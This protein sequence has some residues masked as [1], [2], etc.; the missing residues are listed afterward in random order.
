M[1]A[2]R[3]ARTAL[4]LGLPLLLL[5][6]LFWLTASSSGLRTLAGWLASDQLQFEAVD[7]SLLGPLQVGR[8]RWQSAD[9]SEG[10]LDELQLDWSPV[11]LLAGE[12]HITSVSAK[13]LRLQPAADAPPSTAP[14]ALPL[15]LALRIDQL[16]LGGLDYAGQHWLDE[17]TAS[18]RSDGHHH[19]LEQLQLVRGET[20]LQATAEI[21]ADLQLSAQ[22]EL[23]SQLAG[24]AQKLSLALR[25]QLD[26]IDLSAKGEDGLLGEVS[27]RL[28]PF[29]GQPLRRLHLQL[30]KL[31]PAAWQAGWPQ[32][33]LRLEARLQADKSGLTG[34]LQ[35]ANRQAK[36][37]DQ[38]GL[39]ILSLRSQLDWQGERLRFTAL[40]AELPGGGN[41]GGHAEWQGESARL[42]LQASALDL[43]RL[44][45]RLRSTHLAGPISLQWGETQQQ[46]SLDLS[47]RGL[48]ARVRGELK[49]QQLNLPELELLAGDARLSARGQLELAGKGGFSLQG[50]LQNFDPAR[51]ARLPGGRLNADLALAGQ[52][53]PLSLRAR[54][55]LQDSRLGQVPLRGEAEIAYVRQRLLPS[56]L[57]LS[58]GDN[59]LEASGSFGAPEDRLRI[60][61][62]ASQLKAFGLGGELHGQIDMAGNWQQ[63]TLTG[64]LRSPR[65]NLPGGLTLSGLQLAGSLGSHETAAQSL[66]LRL[67]RLDTA[68]VP[69]LLDDLRLQLDGRRGAHRLN[70]SSRLLDDGRLQTTLAGGMN[71]DGQWQGQIEALSLQS[72]D[73]ARNFR[74]AAP[75][76]LQISPQAWQVGDLLLKGEKLDW[77]ARL[78]AQANGREL[79][80]SGQA[81]GSRL[82]E[83]SLELQAGLQDAYTLAPGAPWQGGLRARIADLAWLGESLGEGWQSGGQIDARISLAG[84]PAAPRFSGQVSGQQLALRLPEQG[85]HLSDGVLD[86]RLQAQKLRIER[87]HFASRLQAPPRALTQALQRDAEDR[88]AL[89]ALVAQPG[90]LEIGGEIAV[91]RSSADQAALDIRLERLGAW[92]LPDQWLLLS[93]NGRLAWRDGLLDLNGQIAADAGY[94]QLAPGGAPQLS[95]DVFV[96]RAGDAERS[97]LR[98]RR[99]IDLAVD[100]GRRFHFNG[101]GVTTRLAGEVRVRAEGRDL[102][103]A[104]G[105]IVTRGGRFEAYGQKLDIERGVLHFRGLPDNPALD[106]LAVR[107]GLAVEPGVQ[108][109]GTAQKPVVRLVSSPE[110]PEP[111]KLAWLILG[112][113]PEH[114]G[115]G[116]APLLIGAAGGLLGNNAG[117]LIGQIR[118]QFGFDE[119]GIRQGQ[120]GDSGNRRASSRIAGSGIDSSSTANQ[121]FS[122]GKRLSANTLLSYEQAIGKAES[123]VKLTVALGRNLS[124]IGRAGSDNALDLFYTLSFGRPE[125]PDTSAKP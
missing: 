18:L 116:D 51:F 50:T 6:S 26:A 8:L 118:Q 117:N 87:L 10:E 45:R 13:Q 48:R 57:L 88:S 29:A 99:N 71:T 95:D 73:S 39:P 4:R 102:P 84:S 110:L 41:L 53:Q 101:A 91:D 3:L 79:K 5:A 115:S 85:L 15:P 90:R 33:D 98:P 44:D 35:V 58:A 55:Q 89:A 93:G 31:D 59:R 23:R 40:R 65:L 114:L 77:Q 81:S 19:R 34:H 92:Q 24:R 123:I 120:I 94:W 83:L 27:A 61:I 78:A 72:R 106:V 56:R 82:G 62:A 22:G 100:L 111:E 12:L 32:A 38:G 107:R 75:A 76:R 47:D 9:G 37:V 86:L 124:L 7:G 63:G 104:S 97:G 2:L 54:L 119:F 16:L 17:L 46:F 67:A 14:T 30:E 1:T 11:R 112:H 25:G 105:S 68:A 108:I 28:Q 125:K 74:L 52:S 80:L 122:V 21:A 42:A 103:R 121:I 36:T 66:D 20:R 96:R 64:Q 60:V 70:A 109:G 43:L 69:G 113:G 49:G